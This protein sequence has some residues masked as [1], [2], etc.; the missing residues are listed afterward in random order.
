MIGE[1]LLNGKVRKIFREVFPYNGI[2]PFKRTGEDPTRMF[3]GKAD[4]KEP[5]ED[6]IMFQ[7]KCRQNNLSTAFGFRNIIW[8]GSALPPDIYGKIGNAGFLL[9]H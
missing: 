8:S 7:L 3:V 9:Q 5:T 6:S 4:R 2:Y 1:I